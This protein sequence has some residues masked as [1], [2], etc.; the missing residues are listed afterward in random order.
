ML[1]VFNFFV[2]QPA[3][4]PQKPCP[5]LLSFAPAACGMS[6]RMCK[7]GAEQLIPSRKIKIMTK[8]GFI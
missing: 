2:D 8:F 3:A 7:E 4:V 1:V 6:E 5:G